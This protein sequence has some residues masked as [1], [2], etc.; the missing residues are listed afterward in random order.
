[1]AAIFPGLNVLINFKDTSGLDLS[2]FPMISFHKNAPQWR[3]NI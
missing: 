3:I 2:S 1:M